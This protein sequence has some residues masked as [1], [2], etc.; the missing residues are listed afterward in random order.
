MKKRYEIRDPKEWGKI[1][2]RQIYDLPGGRVLQ[3]FGNSLFKALNDV[4]PGNFAF[5]FRSIFKISTGNKIGFQ[6]F[7]PFQK[8]IG[9]MFLTEENSLK[10]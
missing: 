3:Y 1:T 8:A 10:I 5:K 9:E 4:Y 2:T 7:D 6:I